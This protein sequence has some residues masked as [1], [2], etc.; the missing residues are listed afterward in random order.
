[1]TL[2]RIRCAHCDQI[3]DQVTLVYDADRQHQRLEVKCHGARDVMICTPEM[4]QDPE[5]AD[6]WDAI[7]G[8]RIEGLAFTTKAIAL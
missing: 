5:M 4:L 6:L 8:G 7:R 2:P 3:V 1:M